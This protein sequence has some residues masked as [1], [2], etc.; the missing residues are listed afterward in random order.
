[1]NKKVVNIYPTTPILSTNPPIRTMAYK[2]TKPIKDIRAC[3]IAGAK[4]EEILPNGTTIRLNLN[5]YDKDHVAI[6]H[7]LTDKESESETIL[8]IKNTSTKSVKTVVSE[9]SIDTEK[10]KEIP[11]KETESEVASELIKEEK[12]ERPVQFGKRKK[13]KRKHQANVDKVVDSTDESSEVSTVETTVLA[14]AVDTNSVE[15]IDADTLS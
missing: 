7:K 8:K 4:V 15:T 6:Y 3:I 12:T 14:D 1:M 9:V 5:N 2:I 10:S 11:N 13:N